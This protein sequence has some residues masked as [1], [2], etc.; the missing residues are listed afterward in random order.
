MLHARDDWEPGSFGSLIE[1]VHAWWG[2]VCFVVFCGSVS[3]LVILPVHPPVVNAK[4]QNQ[5][6]YRF[7]A[8][9]V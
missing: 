3:T 1:M 6:I 7:T 5:Q 8:L 4:C 2:G 9:M